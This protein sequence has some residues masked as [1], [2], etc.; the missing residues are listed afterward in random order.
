MFCLGNI[1]C[2]IEHADDG[3]RNASFTNNFKHISNSSYACEIKASEMSQI[4]HF[5]DLE[6]L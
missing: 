2:N 5:C 4:L 6:L 3:M 1:V